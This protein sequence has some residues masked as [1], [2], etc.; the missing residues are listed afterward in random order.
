MVSQ[1]VDGGN[2]A[3]SETFPVFDSV[4]GGYGMGI[5]VARRSYFQ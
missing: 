2:N 4:P 3:P 5:G 1:E